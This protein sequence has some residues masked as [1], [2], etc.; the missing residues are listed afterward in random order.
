MYKHSCMFN[1]FIIFFI[2]AGPLAQARPFL[3]N[4]D[5]DCFFVLNSDIIC[6]YPFSQMLE[7]HKSHEHEGT[8]AV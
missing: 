2:K 5:C 3:E 7:F 4:S 6:N 8:M 1:K